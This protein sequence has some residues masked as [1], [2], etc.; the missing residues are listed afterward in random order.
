M[1]IRHTHLRVL[2]IYLSL[3]TCMPEIWCSLW[4]ED[5]FD[6]GKPLLLHFVDD[7][8][9]T[10][11]MDET[12]LPIQFADTTGQKRREKNAPGSK[13]L[14][15]NANV[16]KA[17]QIDKDKAVGQI[18][19]FSEISHTG[20]R[21]Y[22]VPIEVYPGMGDFQP[23][24]ALTYN[25]HSGNSILGKGWGISGLQVIYRTGQSIYYDGK[26][27]GVELNGNDQFILDGVRLIK[28]GA[29]S[30]AI[31]YET[32]FGNTDSNQSL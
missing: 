31:I 4:N 23:K 12:F 14:S 15:E 28:T 29:S 32:E 24:I 2:L 6:S 17:V 3:L 1:K 11:G 18:P 30:D 19:I 8:M 16:P 20:S 5:I 13:T 27:S 21:T 7:E 10:G 25:A 26:T 22:N 9:K